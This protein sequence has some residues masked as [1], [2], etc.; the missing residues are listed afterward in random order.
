MKYYKRQL[1]ININE[2]L[3]IVIKHDDFKIFRRFYN[4]LTF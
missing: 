3:D 1:F 4:F 2:I